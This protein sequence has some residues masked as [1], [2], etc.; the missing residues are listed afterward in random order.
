[1]NSWQKLYDKI[2]SQE[3]H[4]QLSN[5]NKFENYC[6]LEDVK[7]VIVH[8]GSTQ[9]LSTRESTDVEL[10]I[11]REFGK[12][13][14]VNLKNKGVIFVNTNVVDNSSEQ[15][16][17]VKECYCKDVFQFIKSRGC[18]VF[19]VLGGVNEIQNVKRYLNMNLGSLE[20]KTDDEKRKIE[21][22]VVLN[23]RQQS[24]LLANYYLKMLY[25]EEIDWY[26]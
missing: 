15:F 2:E 1:M 25:R 11:N 4:K 3:Y 18:V 26:S 9:E 12:S 22:C 24:F 5:V 20:K 6:N 21:N 13:K 23:Y 10:E 7:L 8:S 17:F 16:K 19:I 14:P